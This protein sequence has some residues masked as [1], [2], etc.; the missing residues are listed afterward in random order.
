M[1]RISLTHKTV[2]PVYDPYGR[3][4]LVVTNDDHTAELVHCGL[5]GTTLRL[6]DQNGVIEREFKVRNDW[7][8]TQEQR[9][10]DR[11]KVEILFRRWVGITPDDARAEFEGAYMHNELYDLCPG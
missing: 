9:R 7:E 3:E 8:A 11:T 5:A 6:I 1:R 4:I 2:G 10:A